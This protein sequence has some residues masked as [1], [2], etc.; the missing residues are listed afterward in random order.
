MENECGNVPLPGAQS[1]MG[2]TAE[3]IPEIY[4]PRAGTVCSEHPERARGTFG[5]RLRAVC[6]QTL[7]LIPNGAWGSTSTLN[8]ARSALASLPR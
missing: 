7:S 8:T 5:E 4:P 3:P 6:Q 2:R 1:L